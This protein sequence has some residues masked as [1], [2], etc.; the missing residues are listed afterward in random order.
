M[1]KISVM[2]PTYR[3]P[4]DLARCLKALEQQT[5]KAEEVVVVV[6][7][8]DT[9]TWAFLKDYYPK[10]FSLKTVTVT[11]PGVVAA[12]NAGLESASG[13]VIAITDDDAAPHPD[14][15]ARIETYFLADSRV[16][17]VGGR[18]MIH[19]DMQFT[20]MGESAIVGQLQWHGRVIGNHHIGVGTGREVDLLK[21]VNMAFRRSAIAGM[22]FDERMLGT[23]AQVHF[24]LA[25]SL[26]LRRKGW[27]LI[28]DPCV[29]V[30]HFP[31]KRFDEDQRNKFNHL[32]W[33]NAVHNETLA[34]LEHLPLP[35]RAAF[36]IWAVLV[37]TRE[38]F[39]LV[40]LLRFLPS[41]GKLAIQKWQASMQGRWQGWQTWRS[42]GNFTTS[43]KKAHQA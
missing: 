16:G 38:A 30:D 8:T 23:G 18:D 3:R 1:M 36:M 14:W 37:G 10:T 5:K 12:M 11:L 39:G 27:K 34:L 2:I 19:I 35:R 29:K 40:Q 22:R 21:G 9:D 28:Y 42:C 32:A 25:F 41:Q 24:E 13:D 17:G 43:A 6:R 4:K 7:D 20:D 26:E 15:L 31:A 33:S